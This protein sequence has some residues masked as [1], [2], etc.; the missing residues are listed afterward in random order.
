MVQGFANVYGNQFV[1]RHL[2]TRRFFRMSQCC[3]YGFK[4]LATARGGC[5]QPLT[6]S[7]PPSGQCRTKFICQIAQ[8]TSRHRTDFNQLGLMIDTMSQDV[9]HFRC[10]SRAI[11]KAG[12]TVDLSEQAQAF[13]RLSPRDLEQFI[14]EHGTCRVET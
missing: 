14:I 5:S 10:G 7:V 13:S 6:A 9:G 1:T 4:A 11:F 3:G 2:V 8:T 12:S